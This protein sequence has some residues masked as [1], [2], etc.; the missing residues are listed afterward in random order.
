[1]GQGNKKA[2]K[3]RKGARR[4]QSSSTHTK[5]N[6]PQTICTTETI[7][8]TIKKFMRMRSSTLLSD[9]P[10]TLATGHPM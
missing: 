7:M 4:I 1:M 3:C 2:L 9:V 10:S 8:A 5:N 6:P